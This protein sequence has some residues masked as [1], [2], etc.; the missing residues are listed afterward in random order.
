MGSS[1]GV[2]DVDCSEGGERLSESLNLLGVGC[3][4]GCKRT[5]EYDDLWGVR[6]AGPVM[7]VRGL[8]SDAPLVFLPSASLELPSS[9]AWNRRFSRRKTCPFLPSLTAF[10]TSSPT[11]SLRKVTGVL[12]S[13]SSFLACRKAAR[14]SSDVNECFRVERF[15]LGATY[16]R[17]EAELLN[18]VAVRSSEMGHKDDGGSS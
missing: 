18:L 14:K 4:E 11:Q 16:D 12:R 17:L 1:E 3:R 8:R 13:S 7:S 2:V 10:S 5:G 9:A 6:K 15:G